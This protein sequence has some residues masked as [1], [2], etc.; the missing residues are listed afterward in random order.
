MNQDILYSY[1][2]VYGIQ[3]ELNIKM[4]NSEKFVDWTED[5]FEYVRYNP[6]KPIDR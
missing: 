4:K 6:R 1:L 3:S 2:T 5:N